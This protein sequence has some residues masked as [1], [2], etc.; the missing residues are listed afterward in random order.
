MKLAG[1]ACHFPNPQHQLQYTF[2]L[3][4]GQAFVQAEA[5]ITDE[6]INLANVLMLIIVLEMAFGDPDCV[7]TAEQKLEELTQTDRDFSTYY[8]EFEYYAIEVQ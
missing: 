1:D 5:Y 8:T 6:D 7:A 2:G 3:L 4:V